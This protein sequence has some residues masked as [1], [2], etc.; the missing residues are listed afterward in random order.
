MEKTAAIH[1]ACKGTYEYKW[2]FAN[3]KKVPVLL[4][5]ERIASL[6]TASQISAQL[7]P[8]KI[9]TLCLPSF[10]DT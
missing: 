1:M 4:Q 9:E 7:R 5:A 6:F 3:S 10:K 8:E 2:N